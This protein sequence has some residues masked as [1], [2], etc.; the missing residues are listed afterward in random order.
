MDAIN[1]SFILRS[2]MFFLLRKH[3]SS[4]TFYIKLVELFN[5]VKLL[6]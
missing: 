2:F 6:L 4:Q 5:E 1:D 3:F